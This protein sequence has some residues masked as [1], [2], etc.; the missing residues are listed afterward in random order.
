MFNTKKLKQNII[1][2]KLY[3]PLLGPSGAGRTILSGVYLGSDQYC[4][5]LSTI[6]VVQKWKNV[7]MKDGENILVILT[8]TPGQ[9]RFKA[10][11]LKTLPTASG[12]GIFFDICSRKSYE[13]AQE[14]YNNVR[15]NYSFPIVLFSCKCD[16]IDRRE[17]T[18]NEVEEFSKKK[19]HSLF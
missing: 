17:I 1:K 5:N 10:I 9:E 14:W 16:I 13:E 12:V 18:R 3:I 8:D 15:E 4:N 11:A 6:G 7:I 19:K 2:K